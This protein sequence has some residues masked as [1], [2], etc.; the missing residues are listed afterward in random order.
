MLF[1]QD[2]LAHI[3]DMS[4]LP[5]RPEQVCDLFG[6]IE[7]IYEFN[8]WVTPTNLYRTQTDLWINTYNVLG[9]IWIKQSNQPENSQ[10][11][12]SCFLTACDGWKSISKNNIEGKDETLLWTV[13]VEMAP[14]LTLHLIIL[15]GPGM[16]ADHTAYQNTH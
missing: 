15:R 12:H 2:Y 9:A 4:H 11:S 1:F 14:R 3:I 8:R 6:N 13:V 5:I 10:S 16:V 7:D